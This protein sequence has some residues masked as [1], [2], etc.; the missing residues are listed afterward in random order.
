VI[1]V[2]RWPAKTLATTKR[3]PRIARTLSR[4]STARGSTRRRLIS[5]FVGCPGGL[6]RLAV[7]TLATW[8]GVGAI[9][10]KEKRQP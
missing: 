10:G 3:W 4:S 8:S 2:N 1:P 9:L 6:G 5:A 7:T